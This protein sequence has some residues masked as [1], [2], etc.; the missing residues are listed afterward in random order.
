M[1]SF[2]AHHRQWTIAVI[3]GLLMLLLSLGCAAGV[4]YPYHCPV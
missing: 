2:L 3:V 1:V 4:S